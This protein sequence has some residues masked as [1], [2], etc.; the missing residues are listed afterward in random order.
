MIPLE[1][2]SFC[3]KVHPSSVKIDI[4][5]REAAESKS[6]NTE[7]QVYISLG[8]NLGNREANLRLG[9][10]AIA[11]AGIRIPRISSFYETAPVG[12]SPQ[13][14]F[15]NCVAELHTQQNPVQLLNTLWKVERELGRDRHISEGPRTLDLDILF[16]EKIVLNTRGL[17]LPHPRLARRRFVLV[18]LRE[19][20]E[21]FVHPVRGLS[22]ADMLVQTKDTSPVVWLC[23]A[24]TF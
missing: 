13:Q 8:S 21:D 7:A 24:P 3:V 11:A 4:V 19:L 12:L 22:V 14:W 9:L 17:T 20:V 1:T 18:P 5:P 2:T 16:Y 6:R 15:V 23:R 10:R